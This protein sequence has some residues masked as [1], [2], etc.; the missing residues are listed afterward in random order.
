[1][2]VTS[3]EPATAPSPLAM[4]STPSPSGPAWRMPSAKTGSSN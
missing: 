3:T 2:K 1:M 4:F